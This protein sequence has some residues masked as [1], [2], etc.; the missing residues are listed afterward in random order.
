[1][2]GE[3]RESTPEGCRP[4]G[5]YVVNRRPYCRLRAGRCD[6]LADIPIGILRRKLGTWNEGFCYRVEQRSLICRF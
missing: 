5:A 6:L 3:R 2:P 4:L 1:M